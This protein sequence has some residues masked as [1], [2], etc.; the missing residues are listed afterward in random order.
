MGGET[1]SSFQEI[2][3]KLRSQT[4]ILEK[5]DRLDHAIMGVSDVE[6]MLRKALEIVFEIFDCDRAWLLYPCDPNAKFWRVRMEITKPEYP[7]AFETG[8]DLPMTNDTAEAMNAVLEQGDPIYG[9]LLPGEP[10]WDPDDNYG[11]RAYMLTAVY[12][13]TGKPWEFGLHQCSHSRDWTEGE[14]LLFKKIAVRIGDTLGIF[15]TISDLQKS[16]ERFSLAQHVGNIGSWELDI[17]TRELHWSS[18][19]EPMFGLDVGCY[20]DTYEAYL[21]LIHPDDRRLV[22]DSVNDCIANGDNFCLEHRII[23]PDGQ[24]RWIEKTGHLFKE[25]RGREKK[26]LGISQDVTQRKQAEEQ[27]LTHI[28]FLENLEQIDQVIRRSEDIEI[29]LHDVLSKT[30]MMFD[31]DRCWLLFPCDPS[32]PSYKVPMEVSKP[33]YPGAMQ[34]GL[35]VPMDTGADI[36]LGRALQKEVPVILDR[37]AL[38]QI[39]GNYLDQFDVQSQIVFALHPR[40]GKPWLFGMHQCSYN[41]QWREGE[42]NLFTEIGRRLTD[43]LSTMLSIS[44]AREYAEKLRSTMNSMDDLVF[45]LDEIG[46]FKELHQPHTLTNRHKHPLDVIGRNVE[47][48]FS[49][50][51][52][53]IFL[54]ALAELRKTQEVQKLEYS[55]EHQDGLRWYNARMSQRYAKGGGFEG[56]TVVCRNITEKIIAEREK[57]ALE[58]RLRQS[59]KLETIG[60]LV[61]AV[62][63]D[64]NNLL[65]PI[66]GYSDLMLIS[67]SQ[68]DKEYA[69]LK[70]ITKAANL[71]K[72]LNSQLLAF[73]RKQLLNMRQ[74]DINQTIGD[75]EPLLRSSIRENITL[76]TRFEA[77][78][79]CIKADSSQIEQIL[80]NLTVNAQDAM[81]EGGKLTIQTELAVVDRNFADQYPGIVAGKYLLLTVSD[82]GH[83][84]DEIHQQHIFEPFYTTK[85][86]GKGTG[87]GLATV[88]GIVKQHGGNIWLYSEKGLG[89]IFKIYLPIV[90]EGLADIH[91]EAEFSG[92]LHGSETI[93]ITEDNSG[94]LDFVSNSLKT[95]GYTVFTS[96]H[97]EECLEFF[98]AGEQHIDL[99]ITDL[100]MPGLNGRVLFEILQNLTPDLKV[101]FMSGYS[102]DTISSED[103]TNGIHIVN[104]P[105]TL[106]VLGK[107][108]RRVLTGDK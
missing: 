52:A 51:V 34:L 91:L 74:L 75:I 67:R 85:E 50:D 27:Q 98:E 43:G 20:P 88:Y 99:L 86:K 31:C 37:E 16:Q 21:K 72:D 70:K 11:V 90:E 107:E 4:L 8:Q 65:S 92:D 69:Y 18:Q 83:G 12:P 26:L 103:L 42:A 93:M 95:L 6:E 15:L 48:V 106:S 82:S 79:G 38:D 105:F 47:E 19:L 29:M 1:P 49:R 59:Q 77:G 78:L 89:T 84:I 102:A 80:L 17:D 3:D 66:L 55:V 22:I 2:S 76:E 53:N 56:A 54:R 32:E 33:E 60:Q 44:E 30:L 45:V 25:E 10:E 23:W 57:E 108:I 13:R 104:K 36:V 73:G 61:G 97:A 58:E 63:H 7:G 100:V 41:R 14:A 40:I 101:I 28:R 46:N 5:L 39:Y 24:V 62:A 94:V 9:N 87:L 81:P 71:A 64:L 96:K 68:E 35:E